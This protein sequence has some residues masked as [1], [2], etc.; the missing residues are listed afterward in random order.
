MHFGHMHGAVPNNFGTCSEFGQGA[1][2]ARG[3]TP[4]FRET[5][6]ALPPVLASFLRNAAI[7]WP[8]LISR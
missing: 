5:E 7:V 4:A 8:K 1:R 6:E 3:P 2:A